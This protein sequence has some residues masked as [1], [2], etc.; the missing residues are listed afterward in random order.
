[1]EIV[2]D[3]A[4]S[5]ESLGK[6]LG[7]LKHDFSYFELIRNHVHEHI[8]EKTD[9]NSFP[10]KP[11]R[12]V[13]DVRRVIPTDG[14]VALDNGMYKLWFARNYLAERSNSILLD[15]ALATMGAGLP[16]AMEAARL[17]P[18]KRVMAVCGDGGFMMNSQEME[19]AM[20]MGI[21][22]VVL[23]INDNSYGMIRWKQA[24]MGFED[25]G[26]QYNNPDFVKYAQ[27]YGAHG[28]RVSQ[29]EEFLPLLEKCYQ[30]GGLHLVELPVDYS[31]N[32][33]VLTK[34]LKEKI[35]LI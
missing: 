24:D 31:E 28:H 13:A 16:S 18:D 34:E 27:S 19:T 22:L 9:D 15:N 35:C 14:I 23:I 26:L 20:R 7:K 6:K 10:V 2:G 5:V 21:N 30:D 25:F 33:K 17:F 29:T 11:Q 4:N 3:I 32:H 12:F 1:L 8:L